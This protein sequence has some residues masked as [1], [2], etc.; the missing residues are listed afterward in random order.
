MA[1]LIAAM[2]A[3]GKSTILAADVIA[4]GYENIIEKIQN[5]GGKITAAE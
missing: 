2:C 4:R 1:M 3:K 5:I